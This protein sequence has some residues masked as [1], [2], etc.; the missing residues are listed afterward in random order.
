MN[1]TVTKILAGLVI[2]V[3]GLVAGYFG[4]RHLGDRGHLALLRGDGH[5]FVDM[6]MRRLSGELDLSDEQREKLRPIV[7]ETAGKLAALR[8]EQEPRIQAIIDASIESTK[9]VL[10]PEQFKKFEEIQERLK[11]RRQAF[12]RFGPPP[13]P[14]PGQDGFPPPPPPEFGHIPGLDPPPPPGWPPPPDREP[15][16]APR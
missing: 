9:S 15:P 2:F 1:P 13:P 3:S 16:A 14:P 4:A 6:A 11:K 7:T 5:R 10:T 12:D 8:R